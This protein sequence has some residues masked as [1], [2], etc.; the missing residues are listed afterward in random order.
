MANE[1]FYC[2]YHNDMD[3]KAAGYCVYKHLTDLGYKIYPN[4]FQKHA[5][6]D[7]WKTNFIDKNTTVFIVDLGFTGLT[8]HVLLNMCKLAKEV[9]WIDH[10]QSS[11][12]LCDK[13]SACLSTIDNLTI[14]VHNSACGALLAYA[15]AKTTPYNAWHFI[16]CGNNR[17]VM[18]N[19]KYLAVSTY[20]Q[21]AFT[22]IEI[23]LWLNLIDDYDRWCSRMKASNNFILGCDTMNTALIIK[24]DNG[25]KFNLKFWESLSNPSV[26]TKIT[27]KGYSIKE[28]LNARYKRELVN[29]FEYTL[30]DGTVILCKNGSG[31][32]WCF[33]DEVLH[34]P[35]VCLFSFNGKNGLWIH[36][37]YSHESSKF[38][39]AAFCEQY[40]GG[41]HKHAAGFQI[42]EPV[43]VPKLN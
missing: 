32:S 9:I 4:S 3:G 25:I 16:G 13:K 30:A 35:A 43:F 19:I 36:S 11:I 14:F 15:W 10:H 20:S 17:K 33:Q 8:F 29:A 21:N 28:Y 31:N 23:P 39:C 37:V 38:D 27:Q 40:G 26:V 5:H 41:G 42:K 34:Y 12:D 2:F 1:K 22:N 7:A 24:E 6:G 18:W